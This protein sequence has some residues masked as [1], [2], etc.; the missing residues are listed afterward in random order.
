MKEYQKPI[1]EIILIDESD[2]VTTSGG[3]DFG[4]EENEPT[5]D[6]GDL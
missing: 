3:I 4:D 5:I 6:I 1:I 2:I